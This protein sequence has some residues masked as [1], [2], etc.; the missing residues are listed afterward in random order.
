MH[1]VDL[2]LPKMS[3]VSE[4]TRPEPPPF[5]LAS[6]NPSRSA[7]PSDHPS[8]SADPVSLLLT[9]RKRKLT[10]PVPAMVTRTATILPL[11]GQISFGVT[12][13]D[14]ASG[15]LSMLMPVIVALGPLSQ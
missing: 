7:D 1:D 11:G 14:A 5:L 9:E 15:V 6:T 3:Y 10:I 4:Y 2:L 13:Q 8:E 12:L